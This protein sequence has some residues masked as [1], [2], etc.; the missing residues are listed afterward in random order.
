M[1]P[2]PG[3]AS[4]VVVVIYTENY[5][6]AIKSILLIIMWPRMVC[7]PRRCRIE[8]PQWIKRFWASVNIW[9]KI[10][11]A[12][13]LN[14][15]KLFQPAWPRLAYVLCTLQLTFSTTMPHNKLRLHKAP[16]LHS[17]DAFCENLQSLTARKFIH[18]SCKQSGII[19]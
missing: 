16:R 2:K 10:W 8:F 17:K 7:F 18:L 1:K 5:V 13:K 12:R 9:S 15:Q 14:I 11:A 4:A 6:N 19:I 3:E